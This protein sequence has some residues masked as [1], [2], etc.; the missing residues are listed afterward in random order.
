MRV[1]LL[2]EQPMKYVIQNINVVIFLTENSE[3]SHVFSGRLSDDVAIFGMSLA[4]S[5]CKVLLQ[6]MVGRK[7]SSVAAREDSVK[8]DEFNY[9]DRCISWSYW[10]K[11]PCLQRKLDWHSQIWDLICVGVAWVVDQRSNVH[12]SGNGSPA[13]W[14]GTIPVDGFLL[15]AWKSPSYSRIGL[16]WP[17]L[18]G[19]FL[20]FLLRGVSGEFIF[21][22][23]LYL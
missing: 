8:V 1:R 7:P 17:H 15:C 6:A 12:C 23:N 19:Q 16:Y 21:P 2:F 13:T 9:P 5:K 22:S 10:M 18:W 20:N 11:C 14:F 3:K 4:S